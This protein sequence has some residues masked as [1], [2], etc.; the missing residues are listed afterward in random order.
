MLWSAMPPP[1]CKM[2]NGSGNIVLAEERKLVTATCPNCDR[3]TQKPLRRACFVTQGRRS[4]SLPAATYLSGPKMDR[5]VVAGLGWRDED[6]E[7]YQEDD[8]GQGDHK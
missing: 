6:P 1:D 8:H 7:P 3:T 4:G 2:C 5:D